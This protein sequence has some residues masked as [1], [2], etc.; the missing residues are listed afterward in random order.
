MACGGMIFA[1]N[2]RLKKLVFI[3]LHLTFSCYYCSI[4][5]ARFPEHS[6]LYP[7][8][9]SLVLLRF[10]CKNYQPT[11]HIKYPYALMARNISRVNCPKLAIFEPPNLYE[12]RS[13]VK[14]LFKIKLR[15]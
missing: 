6:G 2:L 7:D 14:Y 12:K 9:N 4:D 5:L 11:R 13:E 8:T 3:L 10:C 15:N 1:K